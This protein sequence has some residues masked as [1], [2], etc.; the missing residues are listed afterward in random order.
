MV[1]TMAHTRHLE[2]KVEQEN[3][4]YN[5]SYGGQC[6]YETREALIGYAELS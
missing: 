1:T 2:G 5:A 4:A 6:A 3:E